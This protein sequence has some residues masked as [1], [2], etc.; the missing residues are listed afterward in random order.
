MDS[1][2]VCLKYDL[3]CKTEHG[4]GGDFKKVSRGEWGCG[5][6]DLKLLIEVLLKVVGG[7]ENTSAEGTDIQMPSNLQNI[8]IVISHFT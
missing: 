7:T 1:T 4:L 6:G 5:D 2:H 8:L 3:N